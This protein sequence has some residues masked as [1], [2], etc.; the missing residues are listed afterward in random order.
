MNARF[1]QRLPILACAG[2]L[3]V[4]LLIN[5]WNAA[6]STDWP[7]LRIRSAEQLWGV[8]AP[9][10][11]QWSLDAFLSGETQKAVSARVGQ[12]QPVFPISVRIR[13][14]FLYSLFGVSGAPDLL[15]GRERTLF[16]KSYVNEF[17]ARGA[18]P[19]PSLVDEWATRLRAIQD[20]VE[21]QGKRFVYLI[22]PSKAARSSDLLP[23]NLTCPA[24]ETKADKLAPYRAAL[25]AQGVA[26]VDGATL[27]TEK[28]ADYPIALFPRGGTHWNYLGAALAAREMTHRLNAD[29]KQSAL[30]D[31]EFDW[32]PREEARGTDIDLLR[33]M[34]LLWQDRHYP[35][36]DIT[37]RNAGACDRR[38]RIFAAG[39]SFTVEVLINL[40]ETPCRPI[41]DFWHYVRHD[42]G[43]FGRGRHIVES[44]EAFDQES[45]PASLT[46]EHF[47][48]ALAGADIVLLE[49]N[50][51]VIAEMGQVTDLF[52][53]TR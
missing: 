8:T 37:G 15:V 49:E 12:M 30:P 32:R 13:N 19:N 31:Y 2:F 14:Q 36:A 50:E 11:P 9:K 23:T 5:I 16:E 1:L 4:M 45:D 20:S 48:K 35:T 21:A 43:N 42:P 10:A 7:K 22:S 53:L 25:D 44:R 40:I 18:A 6:V 33:L 17:C 27:M 28:A 3:G 24:R 41:A 52:E 47:R 51:S 39:G 26:Y 46:P 38:P 34:N 29:G